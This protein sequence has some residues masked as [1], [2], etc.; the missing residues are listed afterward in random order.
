VSIQA[1]I[2]NRVKELQ[3]SM[4]LALLF[5]AHDLSVVKHISYRILVMHPD[6]RLQR[7]KSHTDFA[8]GFAVAEQ[9]A[10]RLRVSH[11][12][13]AG[14]R[15]LRQRGAGTAPARWAE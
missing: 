13:S 7:Q 6:P 9:P 14:D 12:L 3:H 4:G 15:T 2:I 8:R 1:Q 5:I 11:P 10:R